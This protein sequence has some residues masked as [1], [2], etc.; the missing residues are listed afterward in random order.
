LP[1]GKVARGCETP[2]LPKPKG[3]LMDYSKSGNAANPKGIPRFDAQNPRGAP[4]DKHGQTPDKATLLAR[5]K[6]AASVKKRG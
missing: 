3:H 1:L 5:L 4:K 2:D 6:A